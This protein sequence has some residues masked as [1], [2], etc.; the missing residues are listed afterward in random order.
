MGC[1]RPASIGSS[2]PA[3]IA[4][5]TFIAVPSRPHPFHPWSHGA[6]RIAIAGIPP[7]Q[8]GAQSRVTGVRGG[9]EDRTHRRYDGDCAGRL[10]RVL[11]AAPASCGPRPRQGVRELTIC[12]TSS[13][14]WSPR[15]AV[16][17]VYLGGVRSGRR[18]SSASSEFHG[19]EHKTIHAYGLV[20]RSRWR[21]SEVQR[22]ARCGT[23]SLLIVMLDRGRGV[24]DRQASALIPQ[25]SLAASS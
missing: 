18:T 8:V 13:T 14:V 15:P 21:R 9:T 17:Q 7:L 16:R 24:H 22:P 23:T 2:K 20:I 6:R 5:P 3:G 10:R 11:H 19:A 4:T 25:Q 1:R 12:S